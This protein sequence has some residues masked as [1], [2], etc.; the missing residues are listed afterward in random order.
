MAAESGD[1]WPDDR[2]EMT[3]QE[4]RA[5]VEAQNDTM[6]DI[7]EKAM[8]TVRLTAIII[9]LFVTAYQFEDVAFH[10]EAFFIALSAL[11]G[12]ITC[13]V[14]TYDESNLYLGPDGEYI[15]ELAHDTKYRDGW[16]VD[17]LETF[18]G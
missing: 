1:D 7:D 10:V 8:R 17:V 11:I 18:A 2:R 13:G 9:G 15:E 12:S 4:A 5:V 6:K 3:Y 16:E 14:A